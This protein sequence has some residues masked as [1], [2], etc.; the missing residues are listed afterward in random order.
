M[1]TWR[2]AFVSALACFAFPA[3]AQDFSREMAASRELLQMCAADRRQLWG[4][5]LCGPL[6]IVDPATRQAWASQTDYEGV[7]QPGGGGWT[8]VLPAGVPVANSSVEWSGVRW[9]MLLAPLPDDAEQRRVLIAHEAW[10]RAQAAIGLAAQGSDASHLETERGRYFMRLE[11]RALATAMLSRGRARDRAARDALA[12]RAARLA[13]FPQARASESAL[14]RNE[15]LASYTGVKLGAGQNADMFAARTLDGYDRHDA[16]TRS[17]AYASGPAYGLILDHKAPGWRAGLGAF[18][19]A[20]I[21][22]AQLRLEPRSPRALQEDAERYGGQ[23][24]AAEERN[25]AE[26]QRVRIAEFR[27]RFGGGPRLELPLAQMQF[28]F[29][30]SQITPIEGLG[31]VYQ[32]VTLRDRWGEIRA[33]QGALISADFTRLTASGAAPDGLSGPGWRLA[34]NPAYILTAPDGA[35]IIRPTLAPA[36]I[37]PSRERRR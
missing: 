11:L 26:A 2:L 31:S 1:R 13:A 33:T 29:D 15:G 16:F 12:F 8:G 34:L 23:A 17:Y 37:A 27:T 35:G 14:D 32:T 28:E 30:P 7:L 10:H 25:R 22:G 36:A 21:L 6:I 18:T 3:A 4:A 5:D 24:I 19:P 20:D 9:I